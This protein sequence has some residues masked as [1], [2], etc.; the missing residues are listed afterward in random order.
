RLLR[1][2]QA[3][4]IF[5]SIHAES[6]GIPALDVKIVLDER[7][8]V[9]DRLDPLGRRHAEVV[10]ALRADTK[11]IAEIRVVE[12]LATAVALD[13]DPLRDGLL[14]LGLDALRARPPSHGRG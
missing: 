9:H 3:I 4:A 13:P 11:V 6:Q 12:R 10:V 5:L 2:P 7:A 8:L 14:L 1:G